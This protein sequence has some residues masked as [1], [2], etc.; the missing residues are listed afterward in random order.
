M[1]G[2]AEP[3]TVLFLLPSL[4][5]GGA[6][7]V[8]VTLVRHLDP[9][10]FRPVLAVLDGSAPAYADEV[11]SHV[12]L[13]DLGSRRARYSA[14]AVLRTIRRVRP[15]AVFSTLGHVNLVLAALRPLL[16]RGVRLIAREA[17]VHSAAQPGLHWR[18]AYRAL[19]RWIDVV[20][21]QSE[22]MRR[23]LVGPFGVPPERCV[24]VPNPV[25]VAR[26][27]ERAAEPLPPDAEGMAA[28]AQPNVLVAAG[29]MAPEKGFD[30]LLDAMA[31]L[32]DLPIGLVLLGDGPLRA[33]LEARSVALG[34]ADRV[35]FAGHR[36]N[37][38]A[39]FARAGAFV[40]SSRFEAF[41]NVVLEALACGTPVIA[42]PAT[43][44]TAGLLEGVPGCVLA[45][46]V[47]AESL[48]RSIRGFRFGPRAPT[49]AVV[50][51]D[52]RTVARRYAELFTGT[53]AHG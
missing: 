17:A 46:A 49:D 2:T 28:L 35:T 32:G 5:A 38:Y 13:L 41:P 10:Q 45:D 40:L 15:D 24:V 8:T 51:F 39:W 50:P 9:G 16:P 48:A 14:G 19:Y 30:L 3:R 33:E 36:P 47:D 26:I 20:V 27:R 53:G 1:P 11:P 23:E 44:G 4:H 7:R 6:E 34:L 31:R 25:D 29:R 22:A 18:L 21:C 52:A 42:T 37:P 12:P 43:G